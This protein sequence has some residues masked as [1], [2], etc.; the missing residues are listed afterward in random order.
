LMAHIAN[1][2]LPVDYFAVSRASLELLAAYPSPDQWVTVQLPRNDG[3]KLEQMRIA[4]GI[5]MPTDYHGPGNG[6]N[7]YFRIPGD[8]NPFPDN[9]VGSH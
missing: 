7:F 2:N 8:R 6:G 3:D 1:W 5:A 4:G 9:T